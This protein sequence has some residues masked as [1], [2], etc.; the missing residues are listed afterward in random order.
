M[1]YRSSGII[2]EARQTLR[3]EA[4]EESMQKDRY[5]NDKLESRTDHA[6]RSGKLNALEA[7]SISSAAMYNCWLRRF[8]VFLPP[9]VYQRCDETERRGHSFVASGSREEAI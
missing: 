5:V 3:M 6:C 2:G 1:K 8:C 4:P 7:D 9:A